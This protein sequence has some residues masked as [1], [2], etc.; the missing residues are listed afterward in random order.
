M[1]N[2]LNVSIMIC[3][4]HFIGAFMS[5]EDVNNWK[6]NGLTVQQISDITG[7]SKDSIYSQFRYHGIKPI[8]GYK[9]PWDLNKIMDTE[10]IAQNIILSIWIQ[11]RDIELIQRIALVLNNE[12]VNINRRVFTDGKQP[13]V[14]I[15]IGSVELVN[16][17]ISNYGFSNN[18]SK[19]LP[20][21]L[22]LNNPLPYL[23]GYFDGNGYM[24]L[25]CCFST[26]SENFANGLLEWVFKK[27]SIIP[28]VQ[29]V[30]TNKDS[31]NIHFRKK[32]EFFIRDLFQYPG[33]NRKTE[34]YLHYLPN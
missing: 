18:K 12:N 23:R 5:Y 32:H 20:F 15:N 9:N 8:S 28:N 7:K 2:Y 22:F 4:Y 25:S 34:N 13:Q 26:G 31:F 14:N 24:G 33:L 30:G 29:V 17:L 27:Y 1:P 21:P 19:T 10:N 11:E 3:I 16:Y 6:N